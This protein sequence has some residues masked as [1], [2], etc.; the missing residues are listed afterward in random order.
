MQSKGISCYGFVSSGAKSVNH[1]PNAP[2]HGC[3]ALARRCSHRPQISLLALFTARLLYSGLPVLSRPFVFQL[4][5][6]ALL[7]R[8]LPTLPVHVSLFV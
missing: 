8:F 4:S 1:D 3:Y 2:S 5:Q 6:S 7:S